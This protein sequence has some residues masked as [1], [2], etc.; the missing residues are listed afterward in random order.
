MLQAIA[1]IHAHMC[2]M[3]SVKQVNANQD[4]RSFIISKAKELRFEKAKY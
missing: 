1:L 2:N 4:R 3:Q